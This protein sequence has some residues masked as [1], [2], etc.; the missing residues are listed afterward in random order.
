L[1][2]ELKE[3]AE[4]F[5]CSYLCKEFTIEG[6]PELCEEEI[7][8]VNVGDNVQV[9]WS[10]S[11]PEVASPTNPNSSAT[12]FTTAPNTYSEQVTI[13]A[14]LTSEGCG[15]DAVILQKNVHTG[16]PGLPSNLWGPEIVLTGALVKY[17]GGPAEGADHY[18]WWLPHPFDVVD[19]FDYFGDN[20]QIRTTNTYYDVANVFTGFAKNNGYVQLMGVNGCGRGPARKM[21]VTH[22][23]DGEMG[24]GAIPLEQNPG[25][26]P[27]TTSDGSDD[28]V[29]I[30]PN[31]ATDEVNITLK[32][33]DMADGIM[34][35]T[36]LG[37][38]VY[39]QLEQVPIKRLSFP[40]SGIVSTI[41][42][43]RDLRD[44]YYFV[45]IETDKGPV[46]KILLVK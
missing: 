13:I 18:E 3:Q 43:V 24:G 37:V 30:Y 26:Q 5:D 11:D 46:T 34:P 12:A 19:Q 23:E 1:A 10:S 29:V 9:Q 27:N 14:T 41:L 16:K 17:Y 35:S 15:N 21:Y 20:W 22:A 2:N 6:S 33:S 7:Y 4:S 8:F 31:T 40:S 32:S 25:Y 38:A 45:V 42:D 28:G 39:Q 44:G 36:I